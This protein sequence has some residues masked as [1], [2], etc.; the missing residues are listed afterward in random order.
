M[1]KLLISLFCAGTLFSANSALAAT[2]IGFAFDQGFGVAGQFDSFNAFIGNNGI[3]GD[4]L[5]KQG[6]FGKD[7]PFNWYVGGG[8]YY[9]WSGDNSV[10]ARLPLGITIPFA[11]KWDVF[12][13]ISPALDGNVDSEKLSFK[14]GFALGVRYAF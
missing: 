5:F 13:Q 6:S 3:S 14:L 2:K 4:Y 7:V 12:G 10:G 11:Q 8:A 9:N 1:N